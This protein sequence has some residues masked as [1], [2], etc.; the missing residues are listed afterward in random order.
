MGTDHLDEWLLTEE[1]AALARISVGN[2]HWLRTQG[3]GPRASKIG[4]RLLFRR[5]DVEEWLGSLPPA[6]SRT[7]Q[8]SS[9]AG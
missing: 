5:S 8:R 7:E 3:R 1:V 9:A 2:L 6:D 4:R